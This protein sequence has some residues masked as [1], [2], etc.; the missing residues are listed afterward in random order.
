M[1]VGELLQYTVRG[2]SKRYNVILMFYVLTPG[3]LELFYGTVINFMRL[4][5][6]VTSNLLSLASGVKTY[7]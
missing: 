4:T 5:K 3:V 7:R 6:L 2:N 1:D